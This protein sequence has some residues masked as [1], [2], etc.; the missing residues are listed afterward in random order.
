MLREMRREV[1]G[2]VLLKERWPT[3]LISTQALAAALA[4]YEDRL[5]KVADP[6]VDG[7]RGKCEECCGGWCEK[8]NVNREG[9]VEGGVDVVADR[10]S[11]ASIRIASQ[12]SQ[13]RRIR[14]VKGGV[15]GRCGCECVRGYVCG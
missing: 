3:D 2:Q 13:M 11:P 9:C 4:W 5:A 6:E 10:G 12:R 1:R 8:A 7:E 14:R 15:G